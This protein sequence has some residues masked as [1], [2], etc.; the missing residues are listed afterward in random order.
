MT[1]LHSLR[2]RILLA[3][4]AVQ[5]PLVTAGDRLPELII[6]GADV[7]LLTTDGSIC[8]EADLKLLRDLGRYVGQRVLLAVDTPRIE[9]DVRVLP[10]GEQD[11]SR[12]HQWALLGGITQERGQ[13]IEPDGAL[14]FLVV[15]GQDPGSPLLRTAVE[16]QPPLRRKSVPWFAAGRFDVESTRALAAAGCRRIWLTEGG[17][18]EELEQFDEILRQAWSA[19]P[20]HEDYLG[21]A[22]RA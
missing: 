7:V 3:R 18:V 1:V 4:V 13:I 8:R 15:P 16:H 10:P 11:R 20:A 22:V 9:A 12:P 2:S 17:S 5:L 14:Q 19:D 6:G 21:F